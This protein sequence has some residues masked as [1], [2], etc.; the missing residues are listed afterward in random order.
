[1]SG[2]KVNDAYI[3]LCDKYRYTLT[4]VWGEN[5]ENLM[6]F[7]MLNPSTADAKEDDP[8]IRRCVSFAKREGYDGIM[9]INLF[10]LRATDPAELSKHL[11]PM[12]GNDKVLNSYAHRS[13]VTGKPIVCA[14]GANRF[15][16]EQAHNFMNMC[17]GIMLPVYCLGVTKQGHPKHPLYLKSDTPL[18]AFRYVN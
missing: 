3:S 16:K 10:A 12:H 15:A 13:K 18:E 11:D 9:V 8:T 14:W 2:Y 1:M 7:C 6:I 5:V 4:R 17:N